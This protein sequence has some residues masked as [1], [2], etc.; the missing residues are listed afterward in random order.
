MNLIKEMEP[1]L[2]LNLNR[3]LFCLLD[4]LFVIITN[5]RH[6]KYSTLDVIFTLKFL[7][8]A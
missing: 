2:N 4:Q 6:S 3:N 8:N 7:Q 5:N 1:N